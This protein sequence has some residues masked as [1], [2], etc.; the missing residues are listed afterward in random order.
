MANPSPKMAYRYASK[1]KLNI[2]MPRIETGIT[3][4]EK[5]HEQVTRRCLLKT[6]FVSYT[7]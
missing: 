5:W 2:D 7:N 4:N 6:L 3:D 1:L